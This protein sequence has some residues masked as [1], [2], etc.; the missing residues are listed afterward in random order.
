MPPARIFIESQALARILTPRALLTFVLRT[1]RAKKQE[2]EAE[3]QEGEER[4]KDERRTA[5]NP[6]WTARSWEG[7][8][9]TPEATTI[10]L[11]APSIMISL[12]LISA[13][14]VVGAII[15]SQKGKTV[16]F[17]CYRLLD[18]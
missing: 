8:S 14:C 18:S 11:S 5:S 7:N 2:S 10:S 15:N 13:F 4:R 1:P 17:V 3:K 9:G 12:D 16:I 6:S